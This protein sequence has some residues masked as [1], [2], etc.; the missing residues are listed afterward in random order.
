MKKIAVML[1]GMNMVG[2][3][4]DSDSSSNVDNVESLEGEW[5]SQCDELTDGEDGSFI[6]YTIDS[7]DFDEN[8]YTLESI[9]YSDENCEIGNDNVDTYFGRY[10]VGETISSSD[11]TSVTRLSISQ[12]SEDWPEGV[13]ALEFEWVY[14]ISGDELSFGFYQEGRVPEVID[15]MTYTRQ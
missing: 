8:S 15:T 1:F 13:D 14:R 3:G 10:T 12:E 9:S 6:A 2:C 4:G 7:Y 5:V 11:G